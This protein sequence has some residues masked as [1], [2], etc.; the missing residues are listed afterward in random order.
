MAGYYRIV[1]LKREDAHKYAVV[2]LLAVKDGRLGVSAAQTTGVVEPG[3]DSGP[4]TKRR[5][6][7]EASTV[8]ASKLTR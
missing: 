2:R 1:R 3:R 7:R 6:M 5:P 4:K 8:Q